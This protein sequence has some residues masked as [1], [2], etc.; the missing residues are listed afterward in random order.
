MQSFDVLLEQSLAPVNFNIDFL[1]AHIITAHSFALYCFTSLVSSQLPYYMTILL[2]YTQ[3]QYVILCPPQTNLHTV[4][5][6]QYLFLHIHTMAYSIAKPKSFCKA[7]LLYTKF[8]SYEYFSLSLSFVS[9]K[10]SHSTEGLAPLVLIVS[11]IVSAS[12]SLG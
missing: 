12:N 10:Q 6:C 5:T 11:G 9:Y 7:N 1:H 2:L 4:K 8:H 3:P